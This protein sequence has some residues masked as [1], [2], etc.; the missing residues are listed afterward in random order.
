MKKRLLSTLITLCMVFCLVPITA[1]AEGETEE[2]TICTCETACTEEAMNPECLVCGEENALAE[3]CGKYTESAVEDI[4]NTPEEGMPEAHS[5]TTPVQMNGESEIRSKSE[6]EAALADETRTEI[7]LGGNIEFSGGFIISRTVTLD[8]NGYTLTSSGTEFDMFSVYSNGNLTIKDSGTGGKIDGQN[9]NCGFDVSGGTLTLDSGSIVNCTDADGDGGAVDVSSQGKFTMNGGA[10]SNCKAGDDGG[11]IDI[12]KG[13][14]FTMNGGT[15]I[16]CRADDD[17]GAIFVKQKAFFVMNGG[18]I[19]NCSAGY[20][21][22]VNIYRDGSFA[23]TGGT[24]KDCTV[25]A[26][27][28]GNAVYGDKDKAIVAISGGTIENCGE[29]PLSFDAFTVHFDTSGGTPVTDQKVLNSLS[30]RP[31]DPEK[32]G[33]IFKGW[34]VDETP[35]DFSV[36]VTEN[37]TVAAKWVECNHAGS[38]IQPTCTDSAVCSI[39]KGTIPAKGHS[40]SWQSENG[41][42]WQTCSDCNFETVKKLIPEIVINGADRVCRMQDYS[43]DVTLPE[44]CRFITAG[45]EFE[46]IGGDLAVTLE[47]GKYTVEL[48]SS[49]YPA[50]E[51]GF[52]VTVN[53]KTADG[54][55]IKAEKS[56]TIQNEH[57]GGKATC[58][59]K[60]ICDICGETYG[61]LDPM[62]HVDLKYFPAKAASRTA[63][64]TVEYWYCSGCNKYY[65]D[66]DG[67][68]EIKKADTIKVKLKD[69]AKASQTG[70]TNRFAFWIILLLVSGCAVIGITVISRKRKYNR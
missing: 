4:E 56:V 2:L 1:F 38:S 28:S 3:N 12:G 63:E 57:T 6:L 24:I 25:D 15:I 20:G 41:Q 45:Y 33:W 54:F 26:G 5:N 22:A 44:G 35:F 29:S 70:D 36:P 8:L 19:E 17:G 62:N 58:K 49:G 14:T 43:F 69:S 60:A 48:A 27:G 59:D 23:M 50:E 16:G 7:K 66:K 34:Y 30:V 10:I 64:G 55:T 37:M 11:A 52:K 21:G 65:S 51:S 61:E 39:C 13:C 42:Y 47:N 40:F 31:N 9:K 53:A 46:K 18:T 32:A 68:K 67:T